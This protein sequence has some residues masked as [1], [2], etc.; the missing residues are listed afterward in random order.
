MTR[1]YNRRVKVRRFN[2]RHLIHKKKVSQTTKDPSQGKLG[3][4]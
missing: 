2:P 4:N 3:P 1:Y